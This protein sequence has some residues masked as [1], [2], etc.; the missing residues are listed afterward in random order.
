[1]KLKILPLENWMYDIDSISELNL[2]EISPIFKRNGFY[3]KRNVCW[4][5]ING[6]AFIYNRDDFIHSL[7]IFNHKHLRDCDFINLSS[8]SKSG[9][10]NR[11]MLN[12]LRLE[13]HIRELRALHFETITFFLKD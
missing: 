12:I 5:E 9:I 13:T 11:E 6:K 4:F 7:N 1:M 3:L 8:L 10:L 2:K